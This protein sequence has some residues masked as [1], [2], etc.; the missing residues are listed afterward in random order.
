MIVSTA[1]VLTAGAATGGAF[2]LLRTE[3]SPQESAER[4]TA[5]WNRGDLAAMRAETARHSPEP[6]GPP[7]SAAEFDG[8][9]TGL[10]KAL[11]V[12]KTTVRL[13]GIREQGDDK[14][15][16]S[17][18]AVLTLKDIGEWTYQ[19]SIPLTVADRRWRVD[20]T[21]QAVHP[22]LTA[23]RSVR[24]ATTWPAR[25]ALEAAGG[26]RIDGTGAGGSVD[27]LTGYLD[28][29]NAKDVAKLGPAY[30]AGQ[31]IGRGGLQERFEKHLAGTPTTKI[32]LM[33][34]GKKAVKTLSTIEGA[35][36]ESVRTSIDL[37]VQQ[38]AANVV[39]TVKEPASLVALRPSTGEI[40]AVVNNRPG[41]NRAL[42]GR[43]APGSTFKTVTAAALLQAGIEPGQQVTC[44][45]YVTVG[46]LKIRNSEHAEFGSLSFLNSFA[47]SCNTTFAPLAE[48]HLKGDAL[49]EAAE[50]L[51]FNGKLEIGIPATA[52][53]FPKPTSPAE[54][55]AS[56]FG[57]ARLTASPL[58]MA[59]VAA[60]VADGSWR[61][62][63][64]VPD[65]PQKTKPRE[66]PDEVATGLRAMMR[67]VVASGTAKAAGLP[68]G[69]LGKTG[70]AEYGTGEKLESH[71]WFHGY[72]GD[73]AF[74]V[75][76]EGGGGGG[77]IAAPIAA[78]FL[79]ALG[80]S[81]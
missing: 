78:R 20:W 30:R 77:K 70:T 44:P 69:T 65:L 59:S 73:L 46:G 27:Q 43:Y 21:P 41:F 48:E 56:S 16:A 36:G 6:S 47:Q 39:K 74:A 71:A 66:L 1:V 50:L 58:V 15:T 31:T 34:S 54:L 18:T 29:A 11:N 8:V 72:R 64:L 7:A 23:G 63:T 26:E 10:D 25:G 38:A 61:P 52:A 32:E 79:K 13:T 81:Q 22:D 17:Y 80:T 57:Q 12:E 24:L 76:V 2:Y 9:Y 14:A 40:L 45:K 49:R 62:P 28:K 55:A 3:G 42:D 4:F 75:I 67:A 51:G 35:E 5:A 33:G 60:A 19:G 68:Q 37:R 53:S